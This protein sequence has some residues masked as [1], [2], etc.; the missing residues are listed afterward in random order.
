MFGEII[1]I[2]G[3]LI[4]L[5]LF[6]PVTISLNSTRNDGKFGGFF[7]LSWIMFTLCY[8]L[9]NRETGIMFFGRQII[10][11]QGKRMKIKEI[12]GSRQRK[13]SKKMSH[14]R[15]IYYLYR[16]VFRLFKDF[17]Y[18]FRLKYLDIDITFGSEDPAHTGIL[19]GIIHSMIGTLQAGHKVK[20][21][22]DFER[23]V[24]E[25]NIIAEVAIKPIQ[26]LPPITRFITNGQ[27]L[28][29]GF[30]IIRD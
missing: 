27:V 29:T 13:K 26:M 8:T 23:P 5:I 22:A 19:T 12:T 1:V 25:W 16:P 20:W 9:E 18:C 4:L 24:L 10:R 28:K 21:T 3:I 17:I 7:S 30:R 2:L 15:D 11:S 6:F 14:L